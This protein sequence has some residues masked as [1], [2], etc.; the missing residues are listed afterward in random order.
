M[1]TQTADP[2]GVLR[3]VMQPRERPRPGEVC[4]M[5][6]EVVAHSHSHVASLSERRMRNGWI[7]MADE[8][9]NGGENVHPLEFG[10]G[11]EMAR[12]GASVA[13]GWKLHHSERVDRFAH[14]TARVRRIQ[15]IQSGC[16]ILRAF[17]YH[18]SQ[19]PQDP[20]ECG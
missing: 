6:G 13:E 8:R 9:M 3:R 11:I 5:C 14:R 4:E 1:T 18:G 17:L 7:G 20:R 15:R 10:E 16:T 2:F 12:E 19:G